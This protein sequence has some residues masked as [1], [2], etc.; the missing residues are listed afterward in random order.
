MQNGAMHYREYLAKIGA[1]GGKKA[2]HRL[3][4]KKAR[5]MA[6]KRWNW[7]GKHLKKEGK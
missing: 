3:T 6:N 2:K 1:K 4:S 7:S 5:E